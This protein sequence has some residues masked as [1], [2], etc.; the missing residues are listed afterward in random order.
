MAKLVAIKNNMQIIGDTPDEVMHKFVQTWGCDPAFIL[1][2]AEIR[3][4]DMRKKKAIK[5]LQR[6]KLI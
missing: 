1:T 4:S 2:F 5:T 3:A 6:K